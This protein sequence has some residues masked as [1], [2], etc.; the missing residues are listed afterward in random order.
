[1]SNDLATLSSKLATQ[2]RDTT[3]ADWNSTEKDDLINWAVSTL[4]PRRRIELD[5]SV[6]GAEV[7][8]VEGTYFYSAPSGTLDVVRLDWVDTDGNEG[9]PVHGNAW[10][11]TGDPW[12][13]TLKIKVAPALAELGG[14]LRVYGYAK[15]DTSTNLI[16]DYLVSL[17]LA[18][19]RAEAYRRLGADRVRFKNWQTR[20]PDVNVTI[21]ELLQLVNEADAEA[22]QLDL[23]LPTTVQR[24][25]PGRVG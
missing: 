17:V 11:V 18:K 24:P 10:E 19:A 21:N 15:Y 7:S 6:P 5:P 12:A 13:G 3:H 25:V 1:M 9:G 14:K 22:R 4:W 16:P 23:E 20:H 8:L 2:L